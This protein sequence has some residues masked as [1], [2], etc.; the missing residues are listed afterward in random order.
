MDLIFRIRAIA[1]QTKSQFLKPFPTT[2]LLYSTNLRHGC[3]EK[4]DLTQFL[5]IAHPTLISGGMGKS[6][7][8]LN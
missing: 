8:A 3:Q 5:D 2:R 7:T 6:R 1:F 4:I